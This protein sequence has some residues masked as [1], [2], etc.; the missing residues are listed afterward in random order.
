M[1]KTNAKKAGAYAAQP[2][3]EATRVGRMLAAVLADDGEKAKLRLT[4]KV[5]PAGQAQGFHDDF[6]IVSW[7]NDEGAK[8]LTVRTP[9]PSKTLVVM[10]V[11]DCAVFAAK[12]ARAAAEDNKQAAIQLYMAF[13][14]LRYAWT[15]ETPSASNGSVEARQ[16]D[17]CALCGK[18]LKDP[19]SLAR[20]IGPD[21]YGKS[22]GSKTI[23]AFA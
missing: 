12:K 8:M 1:T 23:H 19:E 13:A 5:T 3:N 16:H 20:G 21:C 2:V 7:T 18:K 4:V 15:G 11:L 22:T 14:A 6:E 10:S 17:H 9:Y